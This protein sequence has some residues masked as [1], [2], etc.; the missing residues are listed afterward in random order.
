M[1]S[2]LAS[3]LPSWVLLRNNTIQ[4]NTSNQSS[5]KILFLTLSSKEN[6]QS[7]GNITITKTGSV[8]FYCKAFLPFHSIFI[9]EMEESIVAKVKKPFL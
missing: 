9:Q 6:I 5:S 8:P 2:E 1:V 4:Y 7:E 3:D